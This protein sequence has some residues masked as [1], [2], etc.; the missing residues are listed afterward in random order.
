MT[1]DLGLLLVRIII[2]LAM[3]AH[4]SQKLF[5]WFGGYGLKGTGHFM[6]SLGFRPGVAFATLSGLG[7][8]AGGL[9]VLFGFLGPI[10]PAIVIAVMTVAIMTVHLQKGFWAA[11][12]GY[13][14]NLVYIAGALAAAFTSSSL[15]TL[16]S[17]LGIA[18]FH[19]AAATW[20]FVILGFLGGLLTL[21]VRR[22]PA[23]TKA[24][25]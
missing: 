22:L 14:L 1:H 4:G 13:E 10:G 25:A 6:E 16:D 2:G 8:F 12:G 24:S 3:A 21:V 15:L 20:V 9:L 23:A 17:A 5:G 7:E 18:P 11:N 19:T